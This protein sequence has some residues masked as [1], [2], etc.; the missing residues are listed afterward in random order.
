LSRGAWKRACPVLKGPG[1]GNVS[2]LPDIWGV[3]A[4][5]EDAGP[6]TLADKGYQGSAYAK[7]P[8]KG[9]NKPES[10]KK[11]NKAH[12]KLRSPGERA[13]AQLKTWHILRKLRCCPWR[14]G[15][16]AKA[17]HVLQVREAKAG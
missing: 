15:Q 16:L 8:Y 4:E 6:V 7:I 1:H 17:I 12:A 11:A 9:K 3:L 10:Q 14:A 5:L 13:N 2:R